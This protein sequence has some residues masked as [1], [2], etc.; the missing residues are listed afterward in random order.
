MTGR[1]CD[2]GH[3]NAGCRKSLLRRRAR[4][5]AG[6]VCRRASLAKKNRAPKTGPGWRCRRGGRQTSEGNLLRY[7]RL[8]EDIHP[9]RSAQTM[10]GGCAVSNAA[11]RMSAMHAMACEKCAQAAPCFAMRDTTQNDRRIF[12]AGECDAC[13]AHAGAYGSSAHDDEHECEVHWADRPV[14]AHVGD[15][16]RE[17]VC[18]YVSCLHAHACVHGVR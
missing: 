9:S 15:V 18:G 13:P 11:A 14:R 10:L 8:W 6:R 12:S 5:V 4:K 3:R 7:R 17:H 16:R 1:G 2:A